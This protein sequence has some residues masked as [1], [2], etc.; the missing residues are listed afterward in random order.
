MSKIIDIVPE[1]PNIQFLPGSFLLDAPQVPQTQEFR[2][3]RLPTTPPNLPLP[4]GS[5][6]VSSLTQYWLHRNGKHLWLFC[7]PRGLY[8]INHCPINSTSLICLKSTCFFHLSY[9]HIISGYHHLL[10]SLWKKALSWAQSPSS[11]RQT[12]SL[13]PGIIN[14]NAMWA[15]L[16]SSIFCTNT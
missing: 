11:S 12:Y 10:P 14:R 13:P 1:E 15:I 7:F 8:L 6:K 16:R 9:Y 2:V 5:K 3:S 4:Q